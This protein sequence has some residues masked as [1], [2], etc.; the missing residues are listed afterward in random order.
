M[1]RPPNKETNTPSL[2]PPP[3]ITKIPA[4]RNRLVAL[5]FSL[6][7]TRLAS[8]SEQGTVIRVF[9]CVAC[10]ECM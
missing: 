6:D 8:A 5:T 9:T 10:R 4:H 1:I 3:S 7:G 2:S